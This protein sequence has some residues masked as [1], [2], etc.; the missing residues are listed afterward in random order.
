MP[1]TRPLIL[2]L[3]DDAASAEALELVLRDW[4][5]DVVHGFDA[6][7][8]FA[9]AG[10]RA[11]EAAMIITDFELGPK[12]D[13]VTIAQQLRSYAPEARVLVLSGSPDGEAKRAATD[14]GYAFMPK[15]AA[16][17]SIIAW[18]EQN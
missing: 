16:A 15:P 9:A 10:A 14:A 1:P 8:V 3:E 17:R 12:I 2:L 13:G 6:D 18:I 4:G 11:K 7:H 5:A